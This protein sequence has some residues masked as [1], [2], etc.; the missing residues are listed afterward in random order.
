MEETASG[1]NESN[2]ALFKEFAA[3]VNAKRAQA[4]MQL[5]LPV[6]SVD[7]RTLGSVEIEKEVSAVNLHPL[8]PVSAQTKSDVDRIGGYAC[9]KIRAGLD[10]GAAVSVCPRSVSYTHLTLPT[11]YSV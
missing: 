1:S 6:G 9:E 8:E 10:S 4:P 3:F 2:Q 7:I 11:I 5:S